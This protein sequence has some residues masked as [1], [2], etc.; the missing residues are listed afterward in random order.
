MVIE[1]FPNMVEKIK[2]IC[3]IPTLASCITCTCSFDLWME[4]HQHFMGT[5]SCDNWDFEAYNTISTIMAN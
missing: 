5:L 1:V 3:V 2:E 4:L